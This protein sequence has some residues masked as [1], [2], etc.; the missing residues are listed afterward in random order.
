MSARIDP[1]EVARRVGTPGTVL[2][3][4]DTKYWVNETGQFV[5]VDP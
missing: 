2:I 1:V 4:P 3:Q 5:R